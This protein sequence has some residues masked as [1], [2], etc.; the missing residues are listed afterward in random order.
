MGQKVNPH[1]LRVGV[2]KGWDSRWYAKDDKVGD[3]I[4]NDYQVRK[5]L[6]K[7]LYAAGIPRIEIERDNTRVR[8]FLHCAK[9]GM[10][11]GRGGQ[12]IE[13][14]RLELEKIVG[15]AKGS[16]VRANLQRGAQLWYRA[17]G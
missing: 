5:W 9:P 6:K 13:K 12:D 4:L 2:I 7:K 8:I 3:L 10:V 14:L 16:A 1:G 11:I 17:R 15:K